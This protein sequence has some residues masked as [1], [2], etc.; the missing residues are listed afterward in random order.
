MKIKSKKTQKSKKSG[1][2]KSKVEKI[3]QLSNKERK[4]FSKLSF[5]G[6]N[7]KNRK[8]NTILRSS[9]KKWDH[10]SRRVELKFGLQNNANVFNKSYQVNAVIVCSYR[11]EIAVLC[12]SIE[13]Y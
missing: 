11:D 10:D 8:S 4:I 2:G 6:V 7:Q 3:S 5:F 9:V 12:S 1:M 13:I